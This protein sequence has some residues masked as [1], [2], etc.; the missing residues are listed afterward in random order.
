MRRR[1]DKR[2]LPS[3]AEGAAAPSSAVVDERAELEQANILYS[4]LENRYS[5]KV[6][7]H[8]SALTHT[9]MHISFYIYDL[10]REERRN[11]G[12]YE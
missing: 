10:R 11:E 4:L 8:I 7:I 9:Y 6:F 1:I 12:G 5:R 2:F 3:T